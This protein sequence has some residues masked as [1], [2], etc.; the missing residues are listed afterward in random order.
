[1][2]C[3]DLFWSTKPTCIRFFKQQ[4]HS[5]SDEQHEQEFL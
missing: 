5:L 2:K 4:L 1:M 3:N